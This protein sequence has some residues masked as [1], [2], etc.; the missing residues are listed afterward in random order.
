MLEELPFVVTFVD[1][2]EIKPLQRAVPFD[3]WLD[4]RS[5]GRRIIEN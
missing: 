3:V 4:I 5:F 2:Y 1:P